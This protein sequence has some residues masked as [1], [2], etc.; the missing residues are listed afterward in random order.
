MEYQR[1]AMQNN[2]SFSMSEH[3]H[4]GSSAFRTPPSPVQ[5][6]TSATFAWPFPTN[7]NQRV[8]FISA[9]HR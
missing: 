5:S 8:L 9:F 4:K 2:D 6:H 1:A 7:Q 3:Y